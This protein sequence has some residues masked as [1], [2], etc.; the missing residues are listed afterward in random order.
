MSRANKLV[1]AIMTESPVAVTQVFADYMKESAEIELE[2]KRDQIAANLFTEVLECDVD[3]AL[4]FIFYAVEKQ[5]PG[6]LENAIHTAS[7]EFNVPKQDLI[8]LLSEDFLPVEEN[9]TPIAEEFLSALGASVSQDSGILVQFQN[10]TARQV[11][12]NE[13]AMILELWMNLNSKNRQLME[14]QI[15]KDVL[16]F[17]N[18]LIFAEEAGE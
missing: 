6:I 1:E 9:Y 13:A 8:T 11:E 10:N 7:Q 17:E 15:I 5:G 14:S 18:V 12:C 2:R 16:S 4:D 3:G